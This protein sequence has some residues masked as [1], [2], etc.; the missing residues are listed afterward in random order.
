MTLIFNDLKKKRH[1][2]NGIDIVPSYLSKV[3]N[4]KSD[5]RGESLVT[6]KR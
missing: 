2:E 4:Y 6:F 5:P 3:L 1:D